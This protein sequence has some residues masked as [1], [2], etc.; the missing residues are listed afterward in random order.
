M[1]YT[2]LQEIVNGQYA[3]KSISFYV[4]KMKNIEVRND[5]C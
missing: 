4:T 1:R 5:G 3:A 2:M